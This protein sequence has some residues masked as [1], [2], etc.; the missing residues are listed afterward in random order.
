MLTM[1]EIWTLL[2]TFVL[3]RFKERSFWV[4]MGLAAAAAAVLPFPWNIISFVSGTI[5]SS[6]PDGMVQ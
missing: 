2:K 6:V 1:N 3:N 5:G 4:G